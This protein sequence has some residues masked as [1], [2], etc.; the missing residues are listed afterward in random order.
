MKPPPSIIS[1]IAQVRTVHEPDAAALWDLS[2]LARFEPR[3]LSRILTKL[4]VPDIEVR[5][6]HYTA[7]LRMDLARCNL[8]VAT[9]SGRAALTAAKLRQLACVE[10]VHVLPR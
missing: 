6:V 9:T 7:D 1:L 8:C 10:T 5:T 3:L 2:I 4:A